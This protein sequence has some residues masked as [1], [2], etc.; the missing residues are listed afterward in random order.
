MRKLRLKGVETVFKAPAFYTEIYYPPRKMEIHVKY[1]EYS[2]K[3]LL[4]KNQSAI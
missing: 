2:R 3:K 4:K 1:P